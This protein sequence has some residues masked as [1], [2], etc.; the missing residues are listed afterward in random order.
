MATTK[1]IC[2]ITMARN[3]AFFLEHWIAYYGAILG[4]ENLYIYL[5]GTDQPIP[6]TAGEA[7]VVHCE[8]IPGQ[9]V[10]AERRRLTHLS[11]MASELL[12]KYDLVIG[13][14]ADEFLVLDP[15]VDESLVSYLSKLDINPSVSG[16][17]VDVGQ[18]LNEEQTID[19]SKPFLSQR[20]YGQVS[21]RYTKPV[22]VSKPVRWGAGFHRV[23]GHNFRIDR[24]LYLL[25]FGVFDYEMVKARFQDKDRMAAGWER[26]MKKRSKVIHLVTNKKAK[27][28]DRYFPIARAVQTL[29]RPI[30]ALNKPSMGRWKLVVRLP[31]R[32]KRIKI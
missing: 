11:N 15:N 6:P 29:C 5:D 12:K 2:A 23:K 26:H 16:L 4:K 18:H 28:A 17:G 19:G 27:N 20:S 14:D 3:D 21:S 8:R 25:H 1:K 9:V 10:A 13:T 24:N 22:V 32:F 31:E 30:F 7:T